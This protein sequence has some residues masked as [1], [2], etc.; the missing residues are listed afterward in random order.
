MAAANNTTR[1]KHPLTQP[2]FST[3]C[4]IEYL[5][6]KEGGFAITERVVLHSSKR[7]SRK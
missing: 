3:S 7:R 2:V 4:A 1:D 6:G 5:P